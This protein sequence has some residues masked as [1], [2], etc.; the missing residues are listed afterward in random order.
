MPVYFDKK[1]LLTGGTAAA[2]DSINGDDCSDGDV[3]IV[4]YGGKT[5]IY[6]LDADS[7]ATAD[8]LYTIAPTTNAGAKRWILRH[9]HD[10]VPGVNLLS[11]SGFGVWSNG[12]L[13]NVGSAV[14]ADDCADDG[15]ADW[16]A[17]GA[18]SSIAFDTD[19]YELTTSGGAAQFYIEG[20]VTNGKLYRVTMEVKD[21]TSAG[22][23][24]TLQGHDGIATYTGAQITT[25]ASF[26][27]HTFTWKAN[28]TVD[29]RC[30][31]RVTTD[32]S[33]NNIE[34]KNVTLYEVTPGCIA[35]DALAP[36]GWYKDSTLDVYREHQGATYT[37]NGAYYGLR[38][39]P[40]AVS[41]YILFPNNY[42]S[43]RWWYNRFK[44]R[45]VT[46]GAWV[47]T[48]TASH[49]RL[50]IS[51]GSNHYSS[52]HTGGGDWEW[53][54]V[55]HT[56]SSSATQFYVMVQLALASGD[57]YVCQPM[58]VFGSSLPEG[59]YAPKPDEI[60]WTEQRIALTSLDNVSS[61]SDV[62]AT[63]LYLAAE[64]SGKIPN[65][66]KAICVTARVNDSG[67][68]GTDC[69]LLLRANS[70]Q[71]D[72]CVISPAGL[73]ND[74]IAKLNGWQ[75]CDYQGNI[76]YSIDATGSGT[77]DI[78]VFKVVGIQLK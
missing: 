6:E 27:S 34:I 52:Y 30:M 66:C 7:G 5:Y 76:Q 53:I 23:V 55:T 37:Q 56:I 62:S 64:S 20:A 15:T 71:S 35:A 75:A 74:M 72:Q 45:Q 31:I 1:T 14:V 51:D 50:N 43:E 60:I 9:I 10:D 22:V 47:K 16:T 48:S 38:M 24:V 68:A 78:P 49:A 70:T 39:V 67:S 26:V 42:S 59:T 17:S 65:G 40:S 33:G 36:D 32:L 21:G 8:G 58:A 29:G 44:G 19:H 63:T 2:L 28:A 18:G 11:N 3:T 54:T 69:Y 13:A 25:T 46:F 73:A 77:F 12:V 41:D 61:K 57:V 4:C